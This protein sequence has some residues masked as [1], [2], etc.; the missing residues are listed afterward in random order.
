[1]AYEELQSA[2]QRGPTSG[3]SHYEIAGAFLFGVHRR[4]GALPEIFGLNDSRSPGDGS[5]VKMSSTTPHQAGTETSAAQSNPPGPK[6]QYV[7]TIPLRRNFF[8]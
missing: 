5:T 4:G 3:N 1:L 2:I 6:R 7:L 8:G